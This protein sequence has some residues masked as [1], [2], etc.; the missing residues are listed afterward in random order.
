MH[1]ATADECERVLF[2]PVRMAAMASL[3]S[4]AV[5]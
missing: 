1:P 5:A 2:E 4:P 3:L